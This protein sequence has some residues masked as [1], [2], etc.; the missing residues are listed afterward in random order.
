M[1]RVSPRDYNI[2]N[3]ARINRYSPEAR[4]T[5]IEHFRGSDR[6]RN[7]RLFRLSPVSPPLLRS[8]RVY[9]CSLWLSRNTYIHITTLFRGAS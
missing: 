9:G 7:F 2:R 8:T 6:S 4:F 1:R 3:S 5:R